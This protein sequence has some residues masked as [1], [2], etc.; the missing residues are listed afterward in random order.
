MLLFAFIHRSRKAISGVVV[1]DLKNA[2]CSVPVA[3]RLVPNDPLKKPQEHFLFEKVLH[4][5][6]WM[7]VRIMRP[8]DSDG[9][10][11]KYKWGPIFSP[12]WWVGF[13][14]VPCFSRYLSYK[15]FSII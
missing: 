10:S 6:P 7:T 12:G 14:S 11:D 3:A 2:V 1:F 15:Y 9:L 5:F 13:V 4:I 8:F